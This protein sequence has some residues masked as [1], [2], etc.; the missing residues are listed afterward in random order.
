VR[1]FSILALVAIVA[2][3]AALPAAASAKVQLAGGST[4]LTLAKGTAAALTANGISVRPLRPA[5]VRGGGVAFPITGGSIDP[6][7]GA[8]AIAHSGGLVFRAGSTRVPL[9]SFRV[10]VGSRRAILTA[11]AGSARLTVLSLSVA[12]AKVVRNGL[13]TTVKGVRASLSGQAAKALNAAFGT[14]LFSR[15]LPIGRV[16]V[17]AV[18]A[19]AELAGGDTI[20]ALDSG[21]GTALQSLGITAAPI[22]PASATGAGLLFPITGGKVN[23]ATFAGSISHSGGLRLSRGSTVVD[24]ASFTITV[25]ADPDL[26]ALVGGSR[27]SIL[28]L[29]LTQQARARRALAVHQLDSQ[30]S[31]RQITLSGA[32]ATLTAAAA[33]AL[34]QAFGTTAFTEGFLVGTATVEA[35]AR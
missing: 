10:H 12:N 32:R 33:A 6:R 1:R 20:L 23:A 19:Q 21:A 18:P 14:R 30:V 35:Q 9:R 27:V 29:D 13:G 34:N 22:D 7:S 2:V 24:L 4:T 31:G 3:L 16:V 25:D 5:K 17:R 28:N 15:G 26:T 11:R 8:G